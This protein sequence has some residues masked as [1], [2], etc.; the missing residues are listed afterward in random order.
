[1]SMCGGGRRF[2][3]GARASPTGAS[4]AS[5]RRRRAPPWA[6]MRPPRAAAPPAPAWRRPPSRR[7]ASGSRA[8]AAAASRSGLRRTGRRGW[9]ACRR[10]RSRWRGSRAGLACMVKRS[11]IVNL[12]GLWLKGHGLSEASA[13][14]S[15]SSRVRRAAPSLRTQSEEPVRA[16]YGLTKTATLTMLLGVSPPLSMVTRS[17]LGPYRKCCRPAAAMVAAPPNLLKPCGDDEAKEG[18][19]GMSTHGD[20]HEEGGA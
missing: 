12:G 11:E 9:A 2:R 18:G 8:A 3:L 16:R 20:A 15:L 17:V 5:S 1:M 19:R 10:R 4:A 13:T 14:T 7:D 6:S